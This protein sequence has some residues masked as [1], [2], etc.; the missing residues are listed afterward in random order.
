MAYT[1]IEV[2]R[3]TGISSRTLRFWVDK[4]LFP[5]IEKD[6]KG[7]RYFSEKDLQWVLW[8]D[9][10]RQIGMSIKD[11]KDYIALCA[12]GKNTAKERLEIILSLKEKTLKDIQKFQAILKKLDFKVKYY[13]KMTKEGEDKLNPLSKNYKKRKKRL[14]L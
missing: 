2:E 12:K 1:I 11:L 14:K 5:Y 3:K 10:Y 9:C 6:E 8:I 4:G 7:V 13:E